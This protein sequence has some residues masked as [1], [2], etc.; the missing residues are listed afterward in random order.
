MGIVVGEKTTDKDNCHVK[1]EVNQ[2]S[3]GIQYRMKTVITMG[4]VIK[5]FP[6]NLSSPDITITYLNIGRYDFRFLGEKI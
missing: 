1:R 4:V 2:F 5:R 3:V 6:I